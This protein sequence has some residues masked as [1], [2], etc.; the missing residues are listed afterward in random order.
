M[1]EHLSSKQVTAVRFRHGAQGKQRAGWRNLTV[2][3]VLRHGWF[4]STCF[5]VATEDDAQ[6][7]AWN[8]FYALS[9]K[10]VRWEGVRIA[11]LIIVPVVLLGA[12]AVI[13]A[14]ALYSS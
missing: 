14:L 10:K 4:E 11:M 2:N 6:Q 3:Q 5:H 12:G 1:V 8:S 13:A 7:D 9:E